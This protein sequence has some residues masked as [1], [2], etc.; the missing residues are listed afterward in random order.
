MLTPAGSALLLPD[1]EL[2][3]KLL[4]QAFPAT[5]PRTMSGPAN[6]HVLVPYRDLGWKGWVTMTWRGVLSLLPT[7]EKGRD[8][9]AWSR[10]ESVRG[11]LGPRSTKLSAPRLNKDVPPGLTQGPRSSDIWAPT[12]LLCPPTPRVGSPAEGKPPPRTN[13]HSHCLLDLTV[14]DSLLG[15]DWLEPTEDTMGFR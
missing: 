8:T 3:C 15:N 6:S 4:A 5:L 14:S 13:S 1:A 7:C 9:A 2:G 10:L 12:S 11:T